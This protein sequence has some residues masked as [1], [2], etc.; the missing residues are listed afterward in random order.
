MG[1]GWGCVSARCCICISEMMLFPIQIDQHL[2]TR[3]GAASLF[4]RAHLHQFVGTAGGVGVVE[5]SSDASIMSENGGFRERP[6]PP[7]L[8]RGK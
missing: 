6:R 4:C 5:G 8:T 1:G 2:F 7:S 3:A